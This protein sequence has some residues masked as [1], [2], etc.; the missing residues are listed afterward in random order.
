[1]SLSPPLL[2]V[3]GAQNPIKFRSRPASRNRETRAWGP[4]RSAPRCPHQR[5]AAG[6]TILTG[7][8]RPAPGSTRASPAGAPRSWP[9]G[10]SSSTRRRP[11]PSSPARSSSALSPTPGTKSPSSRSPGGGQERRPALHLEPLATAAGGSLHASEYSGGIARAPTTPAAPQGR[12]SLTTASIA[13]S[14]EPWKSTSRVA[15]ARSPTRV[16]RSEN[17]SLTAPIG[18]LCRSLAGARRKRSTSAKNGSSARVSGPR[19]GRSGSAGA[20]A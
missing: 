18:G 17:P 11:G 12:R 4:G 5:V 16:T 8:P 13:S 14:A 7:T 19:A 20:L 10:S 9:R 3:S 6:D 2:S 1:M 15:T